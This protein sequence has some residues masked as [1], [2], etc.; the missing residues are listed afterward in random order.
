MSSG[1]IDQTIDFF[2]RVII[3]FQKIIISTNKLSVKN[4]LFSLGR[5]SIGLFQNIMTYNNVMEGRA[6]SH[7]K[8]PSLAIE[9]SG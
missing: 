3:L 2:N 4:G 5:I 7:N 6:L 9:I 8:A 1:T